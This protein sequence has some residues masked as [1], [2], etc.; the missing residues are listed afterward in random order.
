MEGGPGGED[1]YAGQDQFRDQ[2]HAVAPRRFDLG[3]V[4]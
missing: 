2:K 1:R 4:D 3:P